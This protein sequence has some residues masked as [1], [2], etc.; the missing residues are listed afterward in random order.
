MGKTNIELG[1][2]KL[3][4][5]I[6]ELRSQLRE[7]SGQTIEEL[8]A[9]YQLAVSTRDRIRAHKGAPQQW[10]VEYDKLFAQMEQ[11]IKKYFA[12]Q[13]PKP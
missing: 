2:K 9:A 12:F 11:D 7:A 10:H 13:K 3:M 1:R 5:K 4:M 6:P 8:F